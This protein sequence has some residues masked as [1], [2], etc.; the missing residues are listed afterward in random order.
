M[1]VLCSIWKRSWLTWRC[2]PGKV[3]L[4]LL[5]VRSFSVGASRESDD[6][7]TAST[8]SSSSSSSFRGAGASVIK[9]D[10]ATGG[11]KKFGPGAART[12]GRDGV[13][14]LRAEVSQ[15]NATIGFCLIRAM[16]AAFS[17]T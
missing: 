2:E 6:G 16:L 4:Q 13:K 10:L 1:A 7:R 15:S 11:N 12:D 9:V 3:S 5:H 17:S 8:A 14:L